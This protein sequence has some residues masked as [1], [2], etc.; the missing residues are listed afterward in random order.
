M[1]KHIFCDLDG[2]LYHGGIENEDADAVKEIEEKGIRFHIA[3]GRIF[4]QADVM[5]R[6]KIKLNGYYI[7]ENGSYIHDSN[8]ELIF[9]GTIDDEIVKKVIARFESDSAKIYFK[10]SGKV[11]LLEKDKLFNYYSEDYIIDPDFINRDSFESAVGNIGII[12]SDIE[13]LSRIELYLESEFSE[14]LDIYFS[15][16]HTLNIVPKGVSKRKS[17]ERVCDIL[18]CSLDEIATIG[19]SPNDINMLEGIKY[20]FAME[21][22]RESV[23]KSANY[24][25]AS[26]KEAIKIIEKINGVE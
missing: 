5:T 26:V 21:N 14:L 19:D 23:K 18:N 8:H 6:D 10:Y 11:L 9:K 17:I 15:S 22:A 13:E 24:V 16:E 3:T 2:T 4:K 1:I 12:S 20:S 7:C 25:C